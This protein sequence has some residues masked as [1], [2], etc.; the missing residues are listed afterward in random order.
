R[1][2]LGVRKKQSKYGYDDVF[3]AWVLTALCG[4]TRLDHI[5]KLKK[6]LNIIPRLKLPSHDTLGRV[7]KSLATE[8]KIKENIKGR[9]ATLGIHKNYYCDNTEL[10]RMLIK[11]TKRAGALKEN[12]AYTIHIDATFIE[13]NCVTAH[14]GK[15]DVHGFYPMICLIN[16]LP[17]Y[18]SMRN[19]DSNAEFELK[20]CL[21]NCLNLLA[22]EKINVNKVISDSAGYKKDL[23]DLLHERGS[24]FYI[25]MPVNISY[26]AMFKQIDDCDNWKNIELETANYIRECEVGEIRYKMHDSE[27][28]NRIIIAREY[29]KSTKRKLV[30]KEEKERLDII[31]NKMKLLKEK[32]LLKSKNRAYKQG[33]WK[34]YK[35]YKIKLI[36]TNDLKTAP[37]EII[38]AYNKR[39]GAE[40]KFDFMKNDF[41]WEYPPFMKMNQNAVFMFA[42]ALA[43][44]I[45]R[46]MVIL[47]KKK[48]PELR[49]NARLSDFQFVFIDVSCAIV[50]GVYEFYNTD[51]AYEKII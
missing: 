46:G 8:I 33:D 19:G 15:D 37:E 5:T 32:K 38:M 47:F 11:A 43:N 9:G 6:K 34:A 49:L 7:M 29:N 12:C 41:G 48:I 25:N 26:K 16:D 45:F 42:A 4:G 13:T 2:T 10:N 40:R 22:E 18:I 21:E 20:E 23:T 27:N 36:I 51:I 24:K 35:Q 50:N 17:V 28:E 30:S 1:S 44:N 3:I 39:G 31:E 14:R